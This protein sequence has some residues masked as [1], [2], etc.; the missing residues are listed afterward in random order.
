MDRRSQTVVVKQNGAKQNSIPVPVTPEQV[1]A[2]M[3]RTIQRVRQMSHQQR[4][5]SLKDA[6]ILTATGKLS[7]SY[8]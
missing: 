4:V 7:A 1:T 5:Q 2:A 6:G 8:R 3:K